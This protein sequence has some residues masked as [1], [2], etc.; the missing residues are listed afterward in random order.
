[1]HHVDTWLE[2]TARACDRW[3]HLDRQVHNQQFAGSFDKAR[4]KSRL[5]WSF[6]RR[7]TRVHQVLTCMRVAHVDQ[8]LSGLFGA[9]GEIGLFLSQLI[10]VLRATPKVRS[11]PRKLL[12]S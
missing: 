7:R 9:A 2:E 3:L 5:Y 4:A 8:D 12:R 6:L 11:S 10:T 1:M